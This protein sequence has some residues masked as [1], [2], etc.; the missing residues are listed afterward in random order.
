MI[1]EL[2]GDVLEP[3]LLIVLTH[4]NDLHFWIDSR[5]VLAFCLV[6]IYFVWNFGVACAHGSAGVRARA[7]STA[8]SK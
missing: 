1:E 8:F 6:L 5:I 3:F 2:A 7:T 4:C